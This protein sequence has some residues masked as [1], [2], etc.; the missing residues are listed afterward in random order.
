MS[1]DPFEGIVNAAPGGFDPQEGM[2]PPVPGK[3]SKLKSTLLGGVQ[4]LTATFG[5]EAD[6]LIQAMGQKWFGSGGGS[7]KSFGDLYRES[8]DSTRTENRKAEEDHKG[9]Y[10]GGNLVGGLATAPLMPGG[11][12]MSLGKAVATGAGVG[13][14]TGLGNSEADISG[15]L[16]GESR[17]HGDVVNALWDTGKSAV[18]GAAIP[19]I[20]K[21]LGASGSA[22]VNGAVAPTSEAAALMSREIPLTVGQMNPESGLAQVEQAAMHTPGFGK[23]IEGQRHAAVNKWQQE[24]VNEVAMPGQKLAQGEPVAMLNEVHDGID[25]AYGVL[26]GHKINPSGMSEAFEA[27]AANPDHM[28]SDASRSKVA[29][30]LRNKA[31]ILGKDTE[32]GVAAESLQTVRSQIRKQIR[33]KMAGTPQEEALAEADMLRDAEAHITG[34]LESQLPEDVSASLRATDSQ[35]A[36]YAKVTDAFSRAGDQ[37]A[38]VTASHLSAAVKSGAN[39]SSYALGGGGPLRELAA[40]GKA[41]FDPSIAHNGASM[42][43]IPATTNFLRVPVAGMAAAANSPS[44]KPWMLGKAPTQQWLQKATETMSQNPVAQ[45]LRTAGGA[46]VKNPTITGTR[47]GMDTYALIKAL[48]GDDNQ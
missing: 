48:M 15:F 41:S 33:K 39:K 2:D 32:N 18:F 11:A 46:V 45:A 38:G 47:A 36:K 35:Y 40:N 34:M 31:T 27:A 21:T 3:T 14:V 44:I 20:G 30:W 6:G 24:V 43:T 17:G 8:R 16:P 37:K 22:L 26:K 23:I 12:G 13:A 42:A 28:V 5:D 10:I 19:T 1:F 25:K 29:S 4:G 7:N 9:Y